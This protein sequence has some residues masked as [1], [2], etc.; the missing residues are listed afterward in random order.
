MA[1]MDEVIEHLRPQVARFP[2]AELKVEI[3]PHAK[4]HGVQVKTSLRL[5]GTTLFSAGEDVAAAPAFQR[6]V[7]ALIEQLKAYK[8]ELSNRPAYEKQIQGT[9][10]DV[11]PTQEPSLE[12]I[13]SAVATGDYPAFRR[14]LGVYDAA[15]SARVGRLVER[16]PAALHKFGRDI[17]ISQIVEDVLLTAFDRFTHRPHTR[18]GQ[19]L[20]DLIEPAIVALTHNDSAER[21]NL[22]FI[23]SAKES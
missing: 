9:A 23:E 19:W 18:L 15:L 21:E 12:E 4:P 5:S 11:A 6:C 10:H 3:M 7:H 20:E 14:A 2:V 16:H 17:P 8:D 13:E 1:K 22:S